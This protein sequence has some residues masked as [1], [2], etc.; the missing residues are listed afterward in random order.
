MKYQLL[1]ILLIVFFVSLFFS[2]CKD[3]DTT[4]NVCIDLEGE[5][6]DEFD[7]V[8]PYGLDLQGIVFEDIN[9]EEALFEVTDISEQSV[10]LTVGTGPKTMQEIRTYRLRNTEIDL[11]FNIIV[12]GTFDVS[13]CPDSTLLQNTFLI[14][15]SNS[16]AMENGEVFNSS[17][18]VTTDI[19]ENEISIESPEFDT[20]QWLGQDF[21]DTYSLKGD[22]FVFFNF[23]TGICG[24]TTPITGMSFVHKETLT[25]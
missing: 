3:K 5:I 18:N 13:N 1:K 21:T 25:N 20:F 24:F 23:E 4:T 15:G 9:G 14:S 19:V 7:A 8:F 12:L 17:V 10:E 11:S 22:F 2:A 6:H 16:I